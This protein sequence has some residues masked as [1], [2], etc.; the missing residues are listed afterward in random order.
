MT[1]LK[2][3]PVDVPVTMPDMPARLRLTTSAQLKALGD[4]LRGRVLGILQQ[5]PVTAKQVAN[6]LGRSPGSIGYQLKLLEK[7]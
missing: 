1:K 5:Q 4:P 2:P 7:T 3:L 6:R